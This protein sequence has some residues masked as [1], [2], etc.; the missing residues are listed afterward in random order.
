MKSIE[1]KELLEYI[2][3]YNGQLN[4]GVDRKEVL[5]SLT[6]SLQ[7]SVQKKAILGFDIYRYSQYELLQQSMIPYYLHLLIKD[8]FEHCKLHEPYILQFVDTQEIIEEFIDMGD[9]GF[10]IFEN[11]LEAIVFTIYF[12]AN[13]KRFNSAHSSTVELRNLLGPLSL[14]YCI[15]YDDLYAYRNNHYGSGIINNARILAKDK[16]NRLLVDR[17]SI[18]WFDVNINGVE[19][20]LNIDRSDFE[21]IK[22]FD[23]YQEKSDGD[24]IGSVIFGTDHTDILSLDVLHIGEIKSKSDIIDIYSLHLQVKL[25]SGGPDF[26]LYT[27]SIGNLNSTNLV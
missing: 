21:S 16:L 11:P 14:R 4:E 20:L 9:G 13:V 2:T 3:K 24:T 1:D 25:V 27:V 15:T 12:Q 10:L 18:D 23:D 17:K 7:K 8:T 26:S 6:N 5:N 22:L 19:N